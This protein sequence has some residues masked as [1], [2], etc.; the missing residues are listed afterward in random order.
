[1][2]ELNLHQAHNLESPRN[3]RTLGSIT[4]EGALLRLHCLIGGCV[5]LRMIFHRCCRCVMTPRDY[6]D[7]T[8]D[9]Q[10]SKM[11]KYQVANAVMVLCFASVLFVLY[12]ASGERPRIHPANRVDF[13]AHCMMRVFVKFIYAGAIVHFLPKLWE[14]EV[15]FIA[16]DFHHVSGSQAQWD[17]AI[18]SAFLNGT[19]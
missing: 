14:F 17:P 5:L 7:N 3:P 1:M 13:D 12:K 19:V 16:D 18:K 9:E 6:G 10:P 11:M 2:N 8:L 4:F 15:N